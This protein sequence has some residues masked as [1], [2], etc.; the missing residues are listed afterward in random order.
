MQRPYLKDRLIEDRDGFVII[1]PVGAEPPV[2]LAC[3]ICDH[4]LHTR[5]DESSYAEFSCCERCARLWAHPRR[6]AWKS[7]WRPT[8][9]QVEKAEAER[10]PMVLTFDV[11]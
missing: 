10:L 5:D 1:V 8:A 9:E 2:P 11:D 3:P 6:E 4:V 7:G